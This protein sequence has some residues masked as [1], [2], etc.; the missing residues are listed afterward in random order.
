M[1]P[2]QSPT[3]G[4]DEATDADEGRL[5]VQQAE[6][7]ATQH[8]ESEL[9]ADGAQDLEDIQDEPHQGGREEQQLAEQAEAHSGSNGDMRSKR[10]YIIEY[11]NENERKRAEYT[12]K[13]WEDAD[14]ERPTGTIRIVETENQEGLMN[15]LISTIPY[16]HIR[17]FDLDDIEI[18]ENI[19]TLTLERTLSASQEGIE[20]TLEFMLSQRSG[21]LID[22]SENKY[23]VDDKGPA[24]VSYE[25][26]ET[27]DPDVTEVTITISGAPQTTQHLLNSFREELDQ[28]EQNRSGR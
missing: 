20:T 9:R 15:K 4:E 17:A 26:G 22:P 8:G 7:D 16:D 13:N 5:R 24:E 12:L 18:D 2:E 23:E 1:S 25:F 28:V 6:S 14:V 27:E 21:A 19:E 3:G 11:G 10:L